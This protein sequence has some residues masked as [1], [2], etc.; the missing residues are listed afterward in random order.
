MAALQQFLT[1]FLLSPVS[2][3]VFPLPLPSFPTISNPTKLPYSLVPHSSWLFR[4][5]GI[6]SH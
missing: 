4:V 1:P 2:K 6:F 3:R 5:R